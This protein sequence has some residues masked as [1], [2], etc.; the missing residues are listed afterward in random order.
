MNRVS[1]TRRRHRFAVTSLILSCLVAVAIPAASVT[2]ADVE[3]ARRQREAAAAQRAAALGN[4]DEAI[5]AYEAINAEHAALTFRV[6]QLRSL[7]DSYE[8]QAA[9][10][11]ARVRDRAVE[12]YMRGDRGEASLLFSSGS[13]EQ[14]VIAHEIRASAVTGEVQVLAAL[15]ATRNEMEMLSQELDADSLR[16]A[17]L[18]REAELVAARMDE[19]FA[20]ADADLDAAVANVASTEAELA[21]QRR[22]E[23]EERRRREEE[24]RRQEALARAQAGPAAGIPLHFTP[25]F[26]CPVAGPHAFVDSWNA[27]RPGGRLH[28]GTDL[29]ARRGTPLVS[30]ANGTIRYGYNSIGGNT[31]WVYADYGIGFFYAHLDTFAE[32][33]RSGDRVRIGQVIGT[34]GDTGNAAPGAY[35]LHFGIA[36][37]GGG[38]DV[39]PYP[40]LRA[41]C[42]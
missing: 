19:L 1:S 38:S 39:N 21:E 25:G 31:A 3:E 6:G 27:P 12:A 17:E 22:R 42:P 4:L 13:F 2:D 20:V 32:G 28:K 5:I 30:V 16:V 36:V 11:E 35:H 9:E 33:I 23:E 29:M 7:I 10:L 37:G 14:A 18:R 8:R 34:V 40:S 26:I 15:L 24:R 41:V